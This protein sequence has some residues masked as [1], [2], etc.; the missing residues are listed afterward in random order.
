MATERVR[1]FDSNKVWSDCQ[2][3]CARQTKHH[4]RTQPARKRR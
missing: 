1:K 4:A 3:R 2:H